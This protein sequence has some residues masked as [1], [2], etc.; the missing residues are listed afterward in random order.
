MCDCAACTHGIGCGTEGVN[1]NAVAAGFTD[2][3]DDNCDNDLDNCDYSTEDDSDDDSIEDEDSSSDADAGGIGYS[4]LTA[5]VPH[6][7]D[8]TERQV[9]FLQ[10][11]VSREQSGEGGYTWTSPAITRR[12]QDNVSHVNRPVKVNTL[13]QPQLAVRAQAIYQ[14]VG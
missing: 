10:Q 9:L 11:I 12:V 4:N 2:L 5:F 1:M 6:C 8:L 7:R 14:G 3:I 13:V